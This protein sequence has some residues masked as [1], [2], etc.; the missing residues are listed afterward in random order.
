MTAALKL[1]TY[2]DLLAL[3]E[4]VRAEVIAGSLQV[5][6]SSSPN[7]SRI[8]RSLSAFVGK[9]FDDDDGFGGPGG[10][11]I[12]VETDV[13][14]SRH[15]IVRPD[16][17][18]I[19][20]DRLPDPSPRPIRVAPD[21]VC[22]VLSPSNHRHD[23]I[24]KRRLYAEHGVAYY[25]IIDPAERTLEALE[26]QQGR[27]V[28]LGIFGDDESPRVAPFDAIELPIGRLFLPKSTELATE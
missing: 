11:W 7:H 15:N 13:Q 20:R 23:R 19:R 28:E 8:Q 3:D 22:E 6:P 16:M 21:W 27:W 9:P 12:F 26:L 25:W 18:G 17:T 24:T 14:L 4:D 10:W 1:A 5:L 2:D